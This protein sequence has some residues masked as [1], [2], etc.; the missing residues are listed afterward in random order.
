MRE[1][2]TAVHR[3]KQLGRGR[4]TAFGAS[5]QRKAEARLDLEHGL[6]T[7]VRQK[8]LT[9]AWQPEV[10]LASGGVVGAEA[11]ARWDRPDQG[12]VPP[13][14]FIPVAE[15]TGLIIEIGE[16]VLDSA[17]AQL[18]VWS[19]SGLVDDDFVV[20]VN[21]SGR[22]LVV[23][24]FAET[25]GELLGRHGRS[26]SQLC[27]E[28]TERVL[29][30]DHGAARSVLDAL[31]SVGVRIAIDDFGTGY[32]SLASLQQMPASHL[33]IDRS[34]ISDLEA[35]AGR[36]IVRAIV[37]VAKALGLR[38]IAE[39]IEEEH[40]LQRLRALGVDLGQGFLLGRPVPADA[41]PD[42][43]GATLAS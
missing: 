39:G 43:D 36:A 35:P 30:E 31:A 2:D 8:E 33:K 3:S 41:L 15:D 6:R 9:V 19:S 5:L 11:L 27:V 25:V 10:D 28:I 4:I 24:G 32:S 1:A 21:V 37:G 29:V 16:W 7:A 23:P 18:D 22:Q 40:Q 42:L 34:F 26:P 14:E 20:A 17:L 13:D 38:T 12:A